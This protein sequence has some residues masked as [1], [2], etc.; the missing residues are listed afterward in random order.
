MLLLM[1]VSR[2]FGTALT[3]SVLSMLNRGATNTPLPVPWPW[4]V[5]IAG[6]DWLPAAHQLSLGVSFITLFAFPAFAIALI[7]RRP[8]W[9]LECHP[10][11]CAGAFMSLTYAHHASVRS[12]VSHLSEAIH[13]ALLGILALIAAYDGRG[14]RSIKAASA[15]ALAMLT[16]FVPAYRQPLAARIRRSDL[17]VEEYVGGDRLWIQRYDAMVLGAMRDR[18]ATDLQTEEQVFFAPNMAGVYVALGRRSP[19]WDIYP[20]VPALPEQQER[21]IQELEEAAIKYAVINDAGLDGNDSLRFRN[22]HPKVW[23]FLIEHFEIT[24]SILPSF[25]VFRRRQ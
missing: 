5:Q 25:I 11:L 14:R 20:V 17:Y 9:R 12:D 22:T 16:I 2:G 6:Q 3:Q 4:T 10:L 8:S 7:V 1:L 21:M 13:P 23:I 24:Q 18:I 19:V 15:I